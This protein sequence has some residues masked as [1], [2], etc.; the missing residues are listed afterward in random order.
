MNLDQVGA[1]DNFFDLGGTSLLALEAFKQIHSFAGDKCQVLDLFKYPTIR[2][3]AT[4]LGG[5]EPVATADEDIRGR[6]RRQKASARKQ[7]G[8]RIR[9][10]SQQ[11]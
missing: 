9:E 7:A 10:T 6:A 8:R 4:Y 3:L 11:V 2:S 1:H 5:G